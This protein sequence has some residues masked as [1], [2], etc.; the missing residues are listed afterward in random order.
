MI[1]FRYH[2]ISIVAIFL[3]LATGIALGAGPLGEEFDQQL[4]NQADKDRQAKEDLR[5]QLEQVD[6]VVEFEGDFAQTVAPQITGSRLA[7]RTVAVFVLP[8]AD[9]DTVDAVT[10]RIEAAGAT[11]TSTIAVQDGLV[12]PAERQTAE[13]IAS[14]VLDGV[15]GLPDIEG[16]SSYQLVGYSLAR[17]YL[18]TAEAG[19]PM[20][21]PAQEIDAA[22]GEANYLTHDGDIARR[23]NL[24]VVIAGPPS[25]E[26]EVGQGDLL[27]TLVQ[28]MDSLSGGVVV[29]GPLAAADDNGYVAAIRDSSAADSVSTVD[30]ADRPSGQ[31]VTVLALVQQGEGAVGQYGAADS[32]D[33]V[34]PELEKQ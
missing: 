26:P 5:D 6:R 13:G 17:G 11:I 33:A 23:A 30:V 7:G 20:D 21:P 28:A 34:L 2:V 15:D 10:S 22:Y 24:A 25:E 27:A 9:D 29:V 8:G 16:A 18:A 1:D 4:A 3:A 19:T 32:A 31:L 12:D 14:R